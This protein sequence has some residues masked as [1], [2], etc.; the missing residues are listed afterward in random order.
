MRCAAAGLWSKRERRPQIFQQNI[1]YIENNEN[2]LAASGQEISFNMTITDDQLFEKLLN[3][4]E[5]NKNE[6][7][8]ESILYGL[9]RLCYENPGRKAKVK[10]MKEQLLLK[11][12]YKHLKQLY[13]KL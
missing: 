7:T 9:N 6:K 3:L 10:N 1:K 8:V 5:T 2:L 4:L 11:E 12:G 13:G